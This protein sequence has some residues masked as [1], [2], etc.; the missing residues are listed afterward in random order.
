VCREGEGTITAPTQA[1]PNLPHNTAHHTATPPAHDGAQRTGRG[2][3]IA[4]PHG[5]AIC[6]E[7]A[8]DLFDLPH[9]PLPHPETPAPA[10]F[11]PTWDATLLV[12]ARRA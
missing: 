9:A 5:R 2:R 1:P 3:Q 11:L 4:I 7:L 10:R 12:H 8:R 6:D